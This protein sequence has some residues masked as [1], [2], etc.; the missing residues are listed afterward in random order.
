[1]LIFIMFVLTFVVFGVLGWVAYT[2]SKGQ[3]SQYGESR[4][5]KNQ[6]RLM[7]WVAA[8]LVALV[9]VF[10]EFVIIIVN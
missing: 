8:I 7:G 6:L 4:F 2:M 1:M 9:A 3:D 10:F 5:T